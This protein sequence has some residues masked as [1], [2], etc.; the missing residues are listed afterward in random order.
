MLVI[1]IIVIIILAAAVILTINNNNPMSNANRARYE[2]DR[3]NVQDALSA[4]LGKIAAEKLS[5][6]IVPAQT[7]I[8]TGI[9]YT[10]KNAND[11]VIG[12]KIGWETTAT[13]VPSGY[14]ANTILGLKMPHYTQD[15]IWSIHKNGQVS[16]MV[17]E[18]VYGPETGNSTEVTIPPITAVEEDTKFK[19]PTSGNQVAVIPKGFKVSS[20]ASEQSIDN[21]LVVIDPDNSEFVWI[22]VTKERLNELIDNINMR[23]KVITWS[24]NGSIQGTPMEYTPTGFREPDIVSPDNTIGNLNIMNS[25]LGTS[26]STGDDFKNDMKQEYHNMY[27]SILAN[28]GFYIGRY[29]T[30]DISKANIVSKKGNLDITNQNW[31]TMY[32]KQKKYGSTLSGTDIHSNM[33]Y[34]FQWDA[35]MKW[36]NNS[37]VTLSVNKGPWVTTKTATGTNTDYREKNIYDMAGNVWD[38]TAEANATSFRV[39]R[40][41]SYMN[42]AS[43]QFAAC[44]ASS[45]STNSDSIYG[46]RM[47]LYL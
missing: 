39:V 26:Y 21:G 19:D 8:S 14:E 36:M 34:G 15:T 43:T 5:S 47:S 33:I 18:T 13:N 9:E 12:G 35:C 28:G 40:G 16:V 24:K 44:R 45:V 30:G 41:A 6:I 7:D 38:W 31:Y 37:F 22:P 27:N 32:A 42:D 2:S 10:L 17:G 3:A 20:I 25:I 1:T 11:G 4:A 23:N 29:E 46:F